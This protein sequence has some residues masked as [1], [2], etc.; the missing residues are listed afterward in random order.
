MRGPVLSTLLLAALALSG[1]S[2]DV[3]TTS[4]RS[5]L[6]AYAKAHGDLPSVREPDGEA[7]RETERTRDK[8]DVDAEVL[9][10]A[11]VEPLLRFPARVGIAR[12]EYGQLSAVPPTEA[13]AWRGLAE[14]LGPE[15][16][17][18][19]PINP[20][21]VALAAG[22]DEPEGCSPNE[23]RYGRC[24]HGIE[25][26][27]HR[28]RLGAARQHVDTVL[29]YEVFAKSEQDTNPLAVTKLVLIGFFMVPSETIDADGFGQA[30]LVDVRNGYTYGHATVAAESAAYTVTTAI[31]ADSAELAVAARAKTAAALELVP[32]VE[33]MARRL[34]LELAEKRAAEALGSPD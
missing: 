33:A 9:A 22:P 12:I 5:Y 29:I 25:R 26:T 15:W 11:A 17:E 18:F 4:G 13:E 30:V 2:Y 32:E 24:R 10:V 7:P 8:A 23:V 6:A 3:Q 16:G 1:C 21:I 28:I 31:N 34:R 19:L 20:L 14:R 27:V